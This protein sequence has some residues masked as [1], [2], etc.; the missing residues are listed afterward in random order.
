M[1]VQFYS[2]A[3]KSS[4]DVAFRRGNPHNQLLWETQ[5]ACLQKEVSLIHNKYWGLIM[6]QALGLVVCVCVCVSPHARYSHL[7]PIIIS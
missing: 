1:D 3:S 5:D 2:Y 4:A 7:L 6:R